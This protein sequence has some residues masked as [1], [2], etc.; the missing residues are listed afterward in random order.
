MQQDNKPWYKQL[1][2]WLLIAIP[3]FTALK[4]IHTVILMQGNIPEMVVD[5]YYKKGQA[6]N[7]QLALYREAELR[8]LTGNV[9]IAANQVIVRFNE[10]KTLGETLQLT[11]YH[12]TMAS[13]D[14]EVKA[15]R[16]GQL[17]YV[18]TL[19]HNLDGHWRLA[20]SDS[21]KAWKLRA[22]LVLPSTTEVQLGY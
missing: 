13:K 17:L 9:L 12:P 3:V 14:F 11:F 2:P 10:N 1:W 19:P 5:D 16:S 4:A 15:Q 21:S 18:A 8:N 7:Q 22:S 6:I 20:V